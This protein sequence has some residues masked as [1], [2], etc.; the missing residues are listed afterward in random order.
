[1][2]QKALVVLGTDGLSDWVQTSDGVKFALGAVSPLR[3]VVEL[4]PSG[5]AARQALDA[6]LAEGK[7]MFSVDVDRM[8]ELL[9]PHR[10]RW[11]SVHDGIASPLIPPSD[12]TLFA[13]QGT[14]M[15]DTNWADKTI[16][17]A[18]TNQIARIEQQIGVLQQ[19]A[20]EA[21]PGSISAD[22]M[23]NQIEGLRDLVAWLRRPSPYGNQSQN[24]TYYG[25]P[26][27][28]PGDIKASTGR[29]SYDNFKANSVLAEGILAKVDETDKK[30]D[31]LVTA[32]K[33]FDAPRAKQDLH[34][35]AS[36]VTEIVANVDLAQPWVSG[37]LA[38]MAKHADQIHGLFAPAKV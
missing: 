3:F 22:S 34:K 28:G 36:R 23:K 21:S 1:M 35:I 26:N 19:H 17:D 10:A 24:S 16:K 12:R 6:F 31:A 38:E 20:K 7:A 15:A 9:K 32:G 37:D 13:R 8:W 4:V 30:I 11:T 14:A 27:Q 25:L 18:V 2:G 5:W 33:K 29:A